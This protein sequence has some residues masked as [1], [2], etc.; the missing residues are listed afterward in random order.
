MK[1]INQSIIKGN[2][3]REMYEIIF[4]EKSVSRIEIAKRLNLSKTTVSCLAEELIGLRLVEDLGVTKKENGVGR[5]PNGLGVVSGANFIAV[6]DWS[7]ERTE[8]RLV[9][10]SSG[11]S[12]LCRNMPVKN[13]CDYADATKA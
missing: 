12:I 2:N 5:N 8:L 1:I 10:I 6:I 13:D 4:H 7:K 11:E 3:L 9:D